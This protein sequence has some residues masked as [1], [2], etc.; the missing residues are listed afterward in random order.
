MRIILYFS[1]L[2]SNLIVQQFHAQTKIPV[3][4]FKKV[5]I[6]PHIETKFVQ[7][8]ENSVT[9]LSSTESEDK[10]NIKVKGKTLRVYLDDA[11][12]WTKGKKVKK[13]NMKMKM[14][15]YKGKVLTILVT[16]INLKSL[17]VR[18]EQRTLCESLIKGEK[19]KLNIY[20]ESEVAFNDV[21]LDKL[22]VDIFGESNF[23]IL[24]GKIDFQKITVYGESKINLMAVENKASKLKAFGEAE[25][26]VNVSERIKF[27][28]YGEAILRHKG[29]AEVS[30]GLSIGDSEIIS[31]NLP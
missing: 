8:D 20:G 27:T 17:S 14:P 18:G 31:I 6:S 30:K 26:E 12:E 11:K 4:D 7:G 9:I 2:V 3:D 13:E 23:T 19:F 16:Y 29:G 28:A 1:V 24:D 22:D 15:I 21:E 25:F 10:I 5:I